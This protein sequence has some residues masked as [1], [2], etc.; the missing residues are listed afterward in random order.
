MHVSYFSDLKHGGSIWPNAHRLGDCHFAPSEDKR[1]YPGIQAADLLAYETYRHLEN[2]HFQPKLRPEW[3][4]RTAFRVL[5][6]KIGKQGRY[7]ESESLALLD[8]ERLK[9][10]H[11]EFGIREVRRDNGAVAQ[12][13]APR[14]QS[15]AGSGES[16]KKAE[17]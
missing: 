11:E 17:G 14:D 2:W 13:S 1:K 7:F 3:K 8:Q 4:A 10:E 5:G 16:S 12:S 15:E 9:G 6:Q